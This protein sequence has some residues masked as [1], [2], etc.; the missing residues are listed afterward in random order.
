MK[1]AGD[2]TGGSHVDYSEALHAFERFRRDHT[3]GAVFEHPIPHPSR[4]SPFCYC[5]RSFLRATVFYLK[6]GLMQLILQLPWNAP[7]IWIL[8]RRGVKIGQNVYIS[9]GVWIDPLFPDLLTMEN[10]ILIGVGARIATHEFRIDTFRAGRVTLRSGS[11][12]GGFSLIRNGVEVGEGSTVGGGA[13]VDRN[14]PP[15]TT[16]IGNPA[17]VVRARPSREGEKDG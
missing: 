7:K 6:A 8:R 14:V 16:V 12:I 4:P 13:V 2:G 9:A 5:G 3:V 10:D 17:R 15:G 1:R 11:V